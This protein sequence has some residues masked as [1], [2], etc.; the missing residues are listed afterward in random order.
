MIGPQD[1]PEHKI[2]ILQ[3]KLDEVIY[4]LLGL[5]YDPA[6]LREKIEDLIDTYQADERG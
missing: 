2:Y 6:D 4:D 5:G 1:S 3:T